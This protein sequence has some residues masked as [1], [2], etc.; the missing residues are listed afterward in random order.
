MSFEISGAENWKA[1]PREGAFAND[2]RHRESS[3]PFCPTT[4]SSGSWPWGRSG[5]S[6]HALLVEPIL[7]GIT[8]PKSTVGAISPRCKAESSDR[9]EL[10]WV[11][12]DDQQWKSICG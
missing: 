11:C 1:A 3:L 6:P 8:H 12:H 5:A 2:S 10:Q 4:T 7:I 9:T